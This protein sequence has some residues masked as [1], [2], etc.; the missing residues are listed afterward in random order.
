MAGPGGTRLGLFL[1]N[2]MAAFAATAMKP[3]GRLGAAV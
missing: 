3:A 1:F 2:R